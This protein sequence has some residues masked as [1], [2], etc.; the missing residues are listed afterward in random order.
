MM[1]IVGS[2]IAFSAS[3]LA[4]VFAVLFV[5]DYEESKALS[6]V[7]FLVL[8]VMGVAFFLCGIMMCKYAKNYP[9]IQ[10]PEKGYF[11]LEEREP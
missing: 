3:L 6:L 10:G 7:S 1:G 8:V 2:L 4:F 11:V 5:M 9:I